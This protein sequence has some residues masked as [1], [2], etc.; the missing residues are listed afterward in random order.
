[1][2][3]GRDLKI[4][5]RK[6]TGTLR[7]VTRRMRNLKIRLGMATTTSQGDDVVELELT[8]YFCAADTAQHTVTVHDGL[9]VDSANLCAKFSGFAKRRLKLNLFG[10][11][12]SPR[13]CISSALQSVR[14]TISGMVS[15]LL[16]LMFFAPPTLASKL[17]LR[18]SL[19]P[20]NPA[21]SLGFFLFGSEC[22]FA[23]HSH[24]M[25]N[26]RGFVVAEERN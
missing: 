6:E 15:K 13:F 12:K 11:G 21:Q 9:E 18:I 5:R 1:M 2:L 7:M 17:T 23:L 20:A 26:L 8:N 25:S 14:L 16:R 19:L 10:I 3:S 22:P 24:S 4:T